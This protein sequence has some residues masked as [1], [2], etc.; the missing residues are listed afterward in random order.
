VVGYLERLDGKN[1]SSNNGNGNK[2]TASSFSPLPLGVFQRMVSNTVEMTKPQ[3]LH[4][5]DK[6]VDNSR[7]GTWS[8]PF[9][10]TL[11]TLP[12]PL[13]GH[14]LM[15]RRCRSTDT[16]DTFEGT[17]LVAPPTHYPHPF[18]EIIE[19]FAYTKEQLAVPDITA[20]SKHTTLLKPMQP[21]KTC[22]FID[23][24][25]Q[26]ADLSHAILQIHKASLL[27]IDLEHHS[28]RSFHG[29]TCLM[30]LSFRHTNN[31]NNNTVVH[32][33]LL[34]TLALPRPALHRHLSPL[35]HSPTIVKV[36]HGANSD[37][38]WLQRDFGLYLVNLFDTG[39]AS[40]RLQKPSASLA[41]L[42]KTYAGLVEI[43]ARKRKHQL[44]DWRVR[45]LSDDV[46]LYAMGDTHYLLDVYD[47]L[48]RELRDPA[49]IAS[50]FDDSR[51]VCLLR[52]TKEPF[53]PEGWQHYLAGGSRKRGTGSNVQSRLTT[54]QTRVLRALH[55]WRD[56][57]SRTLDESPQYV[58]N[59]KALI[60]IAMALPT[61]LT[62]LQGLW[63]PMPVVVLREAQSVL[64]VVKRA[65]NSTTTT[66]S[67][68]NETSS[69]KKR[70]AVVVS[71][72][73]SSNVDMTSSTTLSSTM[74][75]CLF[76][77]TK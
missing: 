1:N 39:L 61:T 26:L 22:H 51:K 49:T 6:Y 13:E 7:T 17:E 60:R 29:L 55:D 12:V 24:E 25:S 56:A 20:K 76:C 65:G 46:V 50:V 59:N 75:F 64:D 42:L 70:K 77:V 16:T 53:D 23:T 37:V 74:V 63:N 10:D 44:G 5:L 67:S 36:M 11:M 15:E 69:E 2:N 33:Y 32:T 72:Q 30:Q 66:S 45:P 8:T 48:K 3:V 4:G 57:T 35:L 21:S 52:Y 47:V 14:G 58:C 19:S 71:P 18:Q 73:Y 62:V 54:I 9:L 68:S 28:Y 43:D 40:R 34:D 38:K 27:A 31:N 41:Y